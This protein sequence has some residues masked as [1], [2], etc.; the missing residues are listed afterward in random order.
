MVIKLLKNLKKRVTSQFKVSQN[1]CK[2]PF[3]KV[4]IGG[5]GEIYF[6][7]TSWLPKA[8]GNI[9]EEP[10]FNKAWN[11]ETAQKIRASMINETYE[12]CSHENCPFLLNGKFKPKKKKSSHD[13]NSTT[14]TKKIIL[15]HGPVE[16][17]LFYDFT[18]NL[19]CKFCRNHVK[20]LD[21]E[22]TEFLLKFQENLIKTP[23]FKDLRRLI[24]AGQGE[25][26]ASKIYLSLLKSIDEKRSPKLRITLLTNGVLLTP[27][28][29]EKISNAHYAIDTISISVDAATKETY[30]KMRRGSNFDILLNNL[31]FLSE[32]KKNKDLKLKATF[33]MQKQNYKEIPAFVKLMKKYSVDGFYF[34]KIINHG[35]YSE[36]EFRRA[37]VHRKD[38]PE[39]EAFLEILRNPVLKQQGINFQ[40]KHL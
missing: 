11:S 40:M 38:H 22:R 19:Y 29:W 27:A 28:N 3:E 8:I 15:S 34:Q 18:C 21:K 24:L 39:Q 20:T 30:N 1:V 26:F 25:V 14:S 31:K 4:L 36:K 6:C 16:M 33:V 13:D 5:Q 32:L 12:F 10:E 23:L 35:T 2:Q 9:F 37:A 17:N 7:C